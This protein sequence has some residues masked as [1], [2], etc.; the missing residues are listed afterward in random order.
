MQ[1]LDSLLSHAATA[2]G[3]GGIVG[4]LWVFYYVYAKKRESDGSDEARR[5]AGV[6][7]DREYLVTQLRLSLQHEYHGK[8]DAQQLLESAR[9]SLAELRGEVLEFKGKYAATLEENM[10]LKGELV[11]WQTQKKGA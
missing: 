4:A 10:R 8:V 7:A 11:Q 9:N 6:A 2:L 3:A 1:W 5:L